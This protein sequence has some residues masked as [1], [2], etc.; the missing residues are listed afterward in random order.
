MR[1]RLAACLLLALGA[2][3][4]AAP[5]D[6]PA[7]TGQEAPAR[8]EEPLGARSAIA[9]E[10]PAAE[11]VRVEAGTRLRSAPDP[12]AQALATIDLAVD[13]EVLERRG[14]WVRVRWIDRL[15]WVPA[16]PRAESPQPWSPRADPARL[17]A[18]RAALGP[19]AAEGR[20]GP[21]LVL[22]D[23]SADRV[24]GRVEELAADLPRAY[25]E[26]FGLEPRLDVELAVVL[27]TRKADYRE[28]EAGH[29]MWE[30][31][32][33]GPA[34]RGVAAL[35]VGRRSYD[36]IRPIVVHELAHLLNRLTLGRDPPAWIEE[37]LAGDLAYRVAG[38]DGR[39]IDGILAWRESAWL[40]ERHVRTDR[41]VPLAELF[42]LGWRELV[43]P[44][45]RDVRYVETAFFVRYLLEGDRGRWRDGFR[46]WLAELAG[47][48][49]AP[50]P[51]LFSALGTDARTL[52]LEFR[53]WAL[54]MAAQTE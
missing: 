38:A 14:A 18:A 27:F 34:V 16:A 20:R 42:D 30:L 26:R 28:V 31:G 40:L 24:R 45:G 41:V 1:S 44:E 3:A 21:F 10:T 4:A 50:A 48:R 12:A 49:S 5:Q 11:T 47:R 33:A 6:E 9:A 22:A 52:D 2:P 36:Q 13:L 19:G 39:R 54:T 15:G 7:P 32:I 51:D 23:P 46:R 8:E 37:G 35:F 53:R 25:A 43:H 29:E 17:A